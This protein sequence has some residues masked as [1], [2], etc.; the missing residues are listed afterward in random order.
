MLAFQLAPV[1]VT[2]PVAVSHKAETLVMKTRDSLF[3]DVF[4]LLTGQSRELTKLSEFLVASLRGLA[5]IFNPA[6][7]DSTH[8]PTVRSEMQL[9]NSCDWPS[10]CLSHRE[11][12]WR[13][14]R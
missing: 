9:P 8:E 13:L 10:D 11:P 6:A 2:N 1:R 12:P 14:A 4:D 3:F 5:Q 7:L